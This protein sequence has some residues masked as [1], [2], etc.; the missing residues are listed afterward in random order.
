MAL[1]RLSNSMPMPSQSTVCSC[2]YQA[3]PSTPTWV[4]LP[5]KQPLRSISAVCAPGA[6]R[7]ERRGQ[8]AGAA[9]DHQHIG[10]EDHVDRAG[11]FEQWFS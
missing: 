1:A 7:G 9:A 8:A 5:P 2:R 11:G 6:R 10:F 4:M 3:K